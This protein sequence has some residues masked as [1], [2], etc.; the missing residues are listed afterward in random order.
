MCSVLSIQF[1]NCEL[2]DYG[3]STLVLKLIASNPP[4][5]HHLSLSHNSIATDGGK[6]LFRSLRNNTNLQVC[7][8]EEIILPLQKMPRVCKV[9]R[10]LHYE[11]HLEYFEGLSKIYSIEMA[12]TISKNIHRYVFYPIRQSLNL[13]FNQLRC[14][15][16]QGLQGVLKS[17]SIHT[18]SMRYNDIAGKGARVLASALLKSSGLK[19]LYLQVCTC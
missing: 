12:H 17:S 19:R 14:D 5:L 9:D 10:C 4:N 18:L 11:Y 15:G 8:L 7:E 3:C 6:A 2:G 16:L 1:H 13:D